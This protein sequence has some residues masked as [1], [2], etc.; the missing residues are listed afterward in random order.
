RLDLGGRGKAQRAPGGPARAK[1][2]RAGARRLC[3]GHP[4]AR[5]SWRSSEDHLGR[6]GETVPAQILDGKALAA[7]V[8]AEV[9]AG[10]ARRKEQPGLPPALPAALG[11]DAPAGRVYARKKEPAGKGGGRS[12]QVLRLPADVG[13]AAL[14]ET[15][16]RLNA[17]RRVHGIL[18]QLPLPKGVE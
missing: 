3:P 5:R 14:I 10:A 2:R 16:D 15:V 8:R 4:A 7:K 18:V 17:D 9:A 1:V 12:G 11:G 13:Q 6:G